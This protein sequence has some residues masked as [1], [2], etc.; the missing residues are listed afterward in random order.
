ME[1]EKN[2]E[3]IRRFNTVDAV[4]GAN[5]AQIDLDNSVFMNFKRY[6]KQE[7][8]NCFKADM[9]MS[10]FEIIFSDEN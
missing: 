9:R 8:L 2:K 5:V 3:S 7:V 1:I 6:T 4:T 10:N